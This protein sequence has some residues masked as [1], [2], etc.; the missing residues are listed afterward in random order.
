M[1]DVLKGD[2][3]MTIRT[4]MIFPEFTNIELINQLRVKYDPLFNK[5]RPHITLVFPLRL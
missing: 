1:K 4:I 2:E 3:F 5:V